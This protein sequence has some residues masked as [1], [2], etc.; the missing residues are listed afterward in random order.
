MSR[1]IAKI[2][3]LFFAYPA[4]IPRNIS[5]L[6]RFQ[7]IIAHDNILPIFADNISVKGIKFY[8]LRI[9]RKNLEK[10]PHIEYNVFC[11]DF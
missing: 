6:T 8:F 4:L 1:Y 11:G 7:T 2:A 10:T 3:R 5:R 9:L